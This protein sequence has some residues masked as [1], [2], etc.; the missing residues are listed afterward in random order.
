MRALAHPTRLALIE[1]LVREGPLTA[2]QAA[3]LLGDS[4]GN[5]SWHLQVLA[6]YGYIEETGT[7]R[8]RSRPWRLVALG[9]R[10]GATSA[11]SAGVVAA[12]DALESL[13]HEQ[14]VERLRQW[15]ANRRSLQSDWRDV[16]FH[17]NSLTYLT[18][19][20]LNDL[21]E[22]VTRALHRYRDRTLD[23]SLRPAGSAPVA[24]VAWGHPLPPSSSGN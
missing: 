24:L 14:G 22:E 1:A 11:S 20:E 2:T 7:G 17:S 13:V 5:I 4:P 8:G 3:N 10:F 16:G 19:E 6:R 18:P 15:R 12:S 21:G 23:R 9:Q